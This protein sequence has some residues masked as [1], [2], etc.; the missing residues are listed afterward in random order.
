MNILVQIAHIVSPAFIVS[1]RADS[2]LMDLR[3]ET[4]VPG[5]AYYRL[6][7]LASAV[8]LRWERPD[9]WELVREDDNEPAGDGCYWR[10]HDVFHWDPGLPVKERACSIRPHPAGFVLS[11]GD[12]TERLIGPDGR[13]LGVLATDG[14]P[15]I[16][17]PDLPPE[18]IGKAAEAYRSLPRDAV[19]DCC[20]ELLARLP[21]GAYW[22]S[23]GIYL[24]ETEAREI[25]RWFQEAGWGV[26]ADNDHGW[27]V[28]TAY[29]S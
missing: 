23:A 13:P 5:A 19:R 20:R 1:D 3:V 4:E 26:A 22:R 18:A 27:E 10:G 12:L 25:A 11:Y 14:R 6:L 7:D 8:G 16:P 21:K 9:G 15:F 24:T 17:A 2:P 29:D 28:S